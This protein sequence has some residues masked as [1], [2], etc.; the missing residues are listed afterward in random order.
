[1]QSTTPNPGLPI[2]PPRRERGMAL[3]VVLLL[4]LLVSA[5]GLGMIYMSNTETSINSN[6]RDSQ[7]AFFAMRAGLE[8]AR[9][10][11]RGNSP[12]PIALPT[13]MPGT[14]NSIAY[15]LNPTSAA[16]PVTPTVAGSTYFDDEFCHENYTLLGL[17]NPGNGIPCAVGPPIGNV[18]TYTSISPNSNDGT[19][20][21]LKYKWAR[22]TL[23]QNGTFAN[24]VAASYVDSTAGS[25]VQVCYQSMSGQQIP[26][27]KIA[28][29]IYATCD[30]A[31]TGG[32]DASPVYVVTSL[33]V[34]PLGSRR[35]GQYEVAKINLMGPPV[36][37]GMDGP[38]A[39]FNPRP[40]SNNFAIDGHDDANGKAN[41]PGC[42]PTG[43]TVPAV[44]TGDAAGVTAIT[45]ELTTNP[46]RSGNYTGTGAAPN[47]V[48]QGGA[49]F[50]GQWST[51]Q[52]LD[53][54]VTNIAN[55]ADKTYT[56][57][58]GTPCSPSGTVSGCSSGQVGCDSTPQI[59]YVNGDFNLGNGSGA[60]VLVVTGTLSFTGNATFDG[61]ILVV[62]QGMISES[63]GGNG[64]F[65]G[66][67]FI[68]QTH[69]TTA[70]YAEYTAAHGL[71][72]PQLQW[73]GGGN[74]F[75]QYNSC[76][77]QIGDGKIYVP[78]ATREEM[79]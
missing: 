15:I 27:S 2:Q 65:N 13:T 45:T 37:L 73:N 57:G 11:M 40:S 25:A 20:A 76:W 63:G 21:A 60:G 17:A 12:W 41:P 70:P 42:V 58:I 51:P 71:G 24:G 28:G 5:I 50:S 43:I 47:I 23:K 48:N 14:P 19:G 72:T 55:N 34:T 7:M 75:I 69:S 36:A 38:A 18:V 56:C 66:S 6:Y 59:T 64:G 32:Q 4:L 67:V 62:G 53:A 74:A 77:S 78:I 29:G 54:M 10:R 39:T 68:A 44:G 79:Y 61:L 46:D 52:Q 9:D 1:M 16:D 30:L 8:E 35:I 49:A 26:V 31:Q 3:I 22:V 33:A